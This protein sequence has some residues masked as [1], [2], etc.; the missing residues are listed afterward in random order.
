MR[1]PGCGYMSFDLLETCKRCGA[2]MLAAT[3]APGVPQLRPDAPGSAIEQ[4]PSDADAIEVGEHDLDRALSPGAV[5]TADSPI[6]DEGGL[7]FLIAAD[8]FAEP[9][10]FSPEAAGDLPGPA[11]ALA[12][13]ENAGEEGGKPII[14]RYEEVPECCWSPEVAGLGRRALAL[15]VDQALLAAAL[16]IFFLGALV[17]LRINDLAPGVFLAAGFQASALPFA[18]LAAGLS[19]GYYC[20]FHA[21]LGRTPGKALAGIE[22]LTGGGDAL[23]WNRAILRWLGAILGLACAGIGIC[24]VFFE[25][26]RRGWADLISGTVVARQRSQPAVAG[27][28]R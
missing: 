8:P 15:L 24:W 11:F 12:G 10:R 22:V 23:T 27:S 2:P 16:G 4:K 20:F 26:R 21:A 18:L 9:R 1:C 13:E 25:P 19:F 17:A 3:V 7:P 6:V 5:S 28:R 14:D